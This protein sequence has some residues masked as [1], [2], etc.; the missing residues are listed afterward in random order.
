M[1]TSLMWT[2]ADHQITRISIDLPARSPEGQLPV[3]VLIGHSAIGKSALLNVLDLDRNKCDMDIVLQINKAPATVN[4]LKE[5]VRQ[6]TSK[7]YVAANHISLLDA[8][9]EE[10]KKGNL[11][12]LHFIYLRRPVEVVYKY[13]LLA[14]TDGRR[15]PHF[16]QE[17]YKIHYATF[18]RKFSQI[19]DTTIDFQGT[20]ISTLAEFF[21]ALVFG[22][23]M[24]VL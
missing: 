3:P 4:A 12:N 7:L 9:Y 8:V 21:T 24:P 16:E 23:E 22:R 15:H 2:L 14:N 11:P 18:D 10:K 19:A 6:G 20:D 5:M 1:S 17:K 13:F